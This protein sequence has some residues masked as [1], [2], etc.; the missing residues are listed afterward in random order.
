[1]PTSDKSGESVTDQT[2]EADGETSRR[3]FVKMTTGAA[4]AGALGALAG[5]SGDG[6]DGG[7][8]DGGGDG[9]GGGGDGGDTDTD[10]GD[11]GGSDTTSITFISANAVEN[12]DIQEHYQSSMEDFGSKNEGYE[13]NL[14]TAS[15]GDIQNTIT[16]AVS[17]GNVPA[18]AESGGLGIQ[19]LK[20]GR[21]ADHQSFFEES[22]SFPDDLTPA[23]Q[24]IA[25]FRDY[26]W[27][28]GA[29]RHTNSNLG[30]RPKTFSQAGVENPMEELNTWSKFYEV[31]Q[32]IDQ[33]QDIIAYE[34][35]GV[36]GDLESYWG[37]AR[38][39]Y[40]DGTDPWMRGE[41]TDPDVVV[42]NEEME[43]D[44]QKTDGMIKA[45]VQLADQFSSDEASQRGD[46]DIPALMLSGRV[47]SFTYALATANRWYSVSEDAQIGW[48]DGEGDFMLLPNPRVD[49]DF[50]NAI[51]IDD[52]SGVEGQ[53]GGHVWGL[54]QCH[55]IFSDVSDQEQEGAWALGQYLFTD[56]DFVLPAWGEY[57]EA[58][59]GMAP[60]M[61]SLRS[62]YDLP[63]NF[64]QSIQ[65]QQEYGAQYSNTGG[66]WNVWPTD[67][68]RW[69]D[70]NE[71]LSQAIAGQHS[72]EE[73]PGIIRDRI[74]TR[75]E[76]ENQ[77]EVPS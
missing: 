65:N 1:M 18:L 69:T 70:I 14:Q 42:A 75:L 11:G 37:Y 55:T 44:R 46:E 21:L 49:P 25:N 19:Y 62:E 17:A 40:T 20:D 54:E 50:G 77:G 27:A 3:D 66:P 43:E 73:T 63:Q 48:N 74:M 10:G 30:I 59:P 60:L 67:P 4:S 9:G 56:E 64:E 47:A 2:A 23:S 72:A 15:Y 45:C 57:Y 58:F 38:T 24:Q 39:A 6:G 33:E 12:G 8:G 61:D 16:S 28:L 35:T 26:W 13:A 41:G 29:I 31:L 22:D 5:C 32:R 7:D 34:E 71:T 51:G 36:P 52:L 76:E 68:I 53:H